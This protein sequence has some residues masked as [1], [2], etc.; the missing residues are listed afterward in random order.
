M[1]SEEKQVE[2]STSEGVDQAELEAAI[3]QAVEAGAQQEAAAEPEREPT[4]HEKVVEA[5][6]EALRAK[7][8]LENFRKRMQRELDTQIKYANL[9]LIRDLIE[10]VDN[11]KRAAEAASSDAATNNSLLEGVNMVT[12]QFVSV[13]GKYGCSPIAALGEEFDPNFHEAIGQTPSEEY[14]SGKVAIEVAGGY[15]LHDRVVRPS[16]VMVSTGPADGE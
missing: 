9:P 11:L 5:Q 7:A 14:A 10:I 6:Q 4:N 1:Q 16:S 12:G 13:L 3:D 2:E 15:R 8:E